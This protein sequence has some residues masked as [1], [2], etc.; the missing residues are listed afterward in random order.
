[1][2]EIGFAGLGTMG[3]EMAYG[4][5][6]GGYPLSVY[7][8]AEEPVRDL[9][10][11]GAHGCASLK[12]LGK[13][14]ELV[15]LMVNTYGQCRDCLLGKEGLLSAMET[16]KTVVVSSTIA[17]DEMIA[18][19]ESCREAGL[20]FL[21]APVSGGKKGAA[22]HALTFMCSGKREVFED[23]LPVLSCMGSNHFYIGCEAGQGTTVKAINQLLF[24]IHMAAAA[25]AFTLGAKCGISPQIL[26]DTVMKS[27][28]ASRAFESRGPK[29]INRDFSTSSTLSIQ[30]KDTDISVR[31]AESA[32][33]PAFL[34]NVSRQL[35][36]LAQQ[37]YDETLDS[38]AV[39]KLYEELAMLDMD[40]RE[41]EQ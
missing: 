24:G 31:T 30:V 1:M 16:G 41:D 32:G 3:K 22:E 2:K 10:A 14:A 34:A 4:I 35:F 28:G 15:I 27:A 40:G 20:F 33:A 38:I 21:D 25:E 26:Y 18:L 12:G 39:I 11:V 23:C 37:R 6:K 9:A 19:A 5:L 7:D 29:V 17:R 8:I 13:R 36:R